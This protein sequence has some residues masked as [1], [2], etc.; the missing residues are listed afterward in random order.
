MFDQFKKGLLLA[1]VSTILI[2][3]AQPKATYRYG[4]ANYESPEPALAAQKAELDSIVSKIT[5][6]DHPIGGSAIIIL[7]SI[8]YVTKNIIIWKGAEPSQEM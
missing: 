4:N 2:S 6:T 5:P 3:C 1:I 8:F 7:P